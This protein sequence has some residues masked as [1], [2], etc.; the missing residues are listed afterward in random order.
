MEHVIGLKTANS[1]IKVVFLSFIVFLISCNLSYGDAKAANA[2]KDLTRLSL[3]ELMGIE[4]DTVY[5]ASKFEQ[6]TTEAPS[7]VS[8]V[9]ASDIKRYG[10]RP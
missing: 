1:F 7:S 2:S 9:T 10:Y 3:E 6:K 8:I 5:G 4:V